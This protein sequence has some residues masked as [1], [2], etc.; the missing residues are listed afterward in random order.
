MHFTRLPARDE[1]LRRLKEVSDDERIARY[2]YSELLEFA[3][4]P[5]PGET[6]VKTVA[7]V[8][9]KDQPTSPGLAYS[10]LSRLGRETH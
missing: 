10:A 3:G 6:V 4:L 8:V 9:K 1:M 2:F 5:L 7:S